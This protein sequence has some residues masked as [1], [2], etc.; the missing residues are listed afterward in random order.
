MLLPQIDHT[1]PSFIMAYQV[2]GDIC[3]GQ[4]CK[5]NKIDTYNNSNKI[6]K[7]CH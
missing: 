3:G 4:Y 1:S 6:I 5:L 7:I 2:D